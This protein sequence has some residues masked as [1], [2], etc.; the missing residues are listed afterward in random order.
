M[1]FAFKKSYSFEDLKRLM[2]ILR[3]EEGCPWD[4]EQ[5][6]QSIR[7]NFIEEVY[8]AAEAIDI[9]DA[10][11]L[12]EELGDV[13]LQV[14]FHARIEQEQ[15]GFGIDDVVSGLCAK[16]VERHPHVFGD[17][18]AENAEEALKN[19]DNIKKIQKKQ[20]KDSQTLDA[21]AKTLP[22]LMR[23]QKICK[24]ANKLGF[25]YDNINNAIEGLEISLSGLKEAS[26]TADKDKISKALGELLF[27]A[28]DFARFSG[29]EAED[30]LTRA[31]DAFI[32][33]AEASEAEPE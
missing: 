13:L 27:A 29:S 25:S 16:L 5:T 17:R 4:R 26:E 24:R 11:L 30:C 19:W 33:K 1:E 21:V 28:A 9:G 22:A 20:T 18:R 3:G 6:H 15:G 12:R 7:Y 8:E 32:K 31:S 2:E 14:V 10:G 23:A